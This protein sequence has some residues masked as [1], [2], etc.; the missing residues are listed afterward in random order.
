[1]SDEGAVEAA[2]E[3][4]ILAYPKVVE[5]YK[6]GKIQAAKFLFGLVMREMKGKADP[7]AVQKV[8]EEKLGGLQ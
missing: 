4:V 3:K 1:M 6:S 5:D 2:I 7:Q 8:L